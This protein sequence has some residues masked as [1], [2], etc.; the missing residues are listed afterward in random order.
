MASITLDY[1]ARNV[2]AR[3]ALDYILSLGVF[4]EKKKMTGLE[5][6]FEDID[7]G[8]VHRLITPQRLNG[9]G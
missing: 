7:A 8:R 2:Q 3:K 5:R 4:K 1:N 9:N 6:A